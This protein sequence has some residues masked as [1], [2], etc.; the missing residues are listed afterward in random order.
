MKNKLFK[1]DGS[2]KCNWC[3]NKEDIL[4]VQYFGLSQSTC[5][6]GSDIYYNTSD[7]Y[8]LSQ[9]IF[10]SPT[11]KKY[12][13]IYINYKDG[14]CRLTDSGSFNSTK[15]SISLRKYIKNRDDL[16]EL[17]DRIDKLLSIG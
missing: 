1:Y 3:G 9:F 2:L 14:T 6:C 8:I 4:Q 7:L 13:Y 16:E 10:I 11:Y 15:V 17:V 12:N 5:R